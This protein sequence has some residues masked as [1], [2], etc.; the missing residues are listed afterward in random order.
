MKYL[1][2]LCVLAG[3]SVP[4]QTPIPELAS[5][6]PMIEVRAT[7][8]EPKEKVTV[9][10]NGKSKPCADIDAGDAEESVHLKFDC[11]LSLKR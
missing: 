10:R 2:I 11:L 7:R 6:S 5:M 3:C 4:P 8:E 1:F 9:I